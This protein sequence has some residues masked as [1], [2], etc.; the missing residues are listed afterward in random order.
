[1]AKLSIYNKILKKTH[2]IKDEVTF[3]RSESSGNVHYEDD[4]LSREHFKVMIRNNK[5]YIVDLG[6]RNGTLVNGKQMPKNHAY[7]LKHGDCIEAGNQNLA[8][9]LIGQSAEETNSDRDL[10]SEVFKQEHR[11]IEKV[12]VESEFSIDKR[13]VEHKTPKLN[14]KNS[15]EFDYDDSNVKI[16]S[17]G[18]YANF[19]QRLGASL[20]D[21]II[22]GVISKVI[23]I[24]IILAMP[25]FKG[26]MG[27]ELGSSIIIGMIV[28]YFVVIRPL[29]ECGQSPG[30]K[31]LGIKVVTDS[32]EHPSKAT[33][34]LREYLY[35]YITTLF[36]IITLPIYWFD[37]NNKF[38]HDHFA[39]TRVINL[40]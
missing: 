13:A 33:F 3:G 17:G 26:N 4:D 31:I 10:T 2:I 9:R 28:A 1:V 6:S 14:P 22:N 25:Q 27:F 32:L 21:G 23:G 39:S 38:T 30:K 5:G 18:D 16:I 29:I 8:V 35:K 37:K 24:I 36:I 34:L 7:E 15:N 40:N 12:V 19:W 11:P 20:I